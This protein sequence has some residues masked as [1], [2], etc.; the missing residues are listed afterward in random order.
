MN[1][2]KESPETR[3][4]DS[5]TAGKRI[6]LPGHIHLDLRV[7]VREINLAPSKTFDGKT[8]ALTIKVGKEKEETDKPEPKY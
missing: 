6:Y 4:A 2:T 8:E 1:A 3:A 7:P 5:I